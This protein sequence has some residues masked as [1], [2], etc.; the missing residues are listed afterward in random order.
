M[1]GPPR[2][3]KVSRRLRRGRHARLRL[4]SVATARYASALNPVRRIGGVSPRTAP[5]EEP[6]L[7]LTVEPA[8][9][10]PSQRRASVAAVLILLAAGVFTLKGFLPALI[11]AA[12][13]AIAMWPSFDR[14]ATRFP[15]HRHELLPAAA[16]LGVLLVFVVPVLMVALP[17]ITDAH[18]ASDW[19]AHARQ[20]G[21]APPPILSSLPF[22]DRLVPL[23]QRNLGEPGEISALPARIMQG[24]LIETARGVGAE[25]LHRVVLLAFML[26]AL[27][28]LLRE[29]DGVARQVRA[30]SARTFGPRGERVG[31]Q[32]ILSIHGT[33]NGL[34][35]VGLAE[36]VLLGILYW[37]AGVP[38]PALFGLITALLAMV[39]FGAAI[40]FCLAGL[41]L[42]GL[43]QPV[44]GAVVVGIGFAVTFTA[45][46]FIRPALIGGATQ[47]PFL[48]VLLGILG[49]VEAWGLVGLFLGPAIMA[50]LILL[51]RE[52]VGDQSGPLDPAQAKG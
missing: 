32:V 31:R 17:L 42:V 20:Y 38:H 4:P 24:G 11:W 2:R 6:P 33:V 9:S 49:G 40:A 27:F 21:V 37:L 39:P 13:F 36:G 47:L 29:G 25:A 43:G 48:W 51:W 16:V 19:V 30:A 50:A 26:L 34:V 22:G 5:V 45:D 3:V 18:A 10:S 52:W 8:P 46:H 12:I 7:P 1:V 15:R 14:L 28:F 41:L 23:W 44:A 35:L